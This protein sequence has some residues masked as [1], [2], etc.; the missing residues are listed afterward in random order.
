MD[1]NQ[2]QPFSHPL[3]RDDAAR[4]RRG[5]A[6]REYLREELG[7]TDQPDD[8]GCERNIAMYLGMLKSMSSSDLAAAAD[9]A[10]CGSNEALQAAYKQE[11]AARKEARTRKEPA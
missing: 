8:A 4:E 10:Q 6:A 3:L 11:L 1:H 5:R 9:K 7:R 2:A